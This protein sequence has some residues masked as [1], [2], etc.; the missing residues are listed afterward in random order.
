MT[1]S[2]SNR[3][4]KKGAGQLRS[5]G[6]EHALEDPAP[7]AKANRPGLAEVL[8]YVRRGD[9]LIVWKLLYSGKVQ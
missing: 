9:T 7:G 4:I 6:W 3:G 2:H 5:A 8:A 1:D